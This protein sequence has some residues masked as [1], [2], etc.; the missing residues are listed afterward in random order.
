MIDRLGERVELKQGATVVVDCG[1]AFDDNPCRQQGPRP[2]HP[3]DRRRKQPH[4]LRW[5]NKLAFEPT[6]HARCT[7]HPEFLATG[8]EKGAVQSVSCS[9]H[10]R[11]CRDYQVSPRGAGSAH[12]EHDL[13]IHLCGC[14][15]EKVFRCRQWQTFCWY[16]LG[17]SPEGPVLHGIALKYV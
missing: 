2:V 5:S 14:L 7:N 1:M 12:L 13:P 11:V 3:G 4:G 16:S 10:L 15:D 6:N 17:S 9:A 8:L